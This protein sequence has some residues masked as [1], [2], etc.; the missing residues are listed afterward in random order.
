MP[1]LPGFFKKAGFN[2]M[3]QRLISHLNI[4]YPLEVRRGEDLGLG[5]FLLQYLPLVKIRKL[6]YYNCMKVNEVG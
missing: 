2:Y 4:Y 6:L 5:V 3:M 1:S